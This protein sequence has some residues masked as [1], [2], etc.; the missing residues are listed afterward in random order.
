MKI[1]PKRGDF[2]AIRRRVRSGKNYVCVDALESSLWQWW[3]FKKE[4]SGEKREEGSI[5]RLLESEGRFWLILNSGWA[6]ILKAREKPTRQSISN[7]FFLILRKIEGK[8]LVQ[9]LYFLFLNE[10]NFYHL[11]RWIAVII[12]IVSKKYVRV[13]WRK[14]VIEKRPN[15][16]DIIWIVVCC[17]NIRI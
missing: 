3:L 8:S 5:D 14:S 2:R 15:P 17:I 7:G 1:F 9:F 12:W 11:K 13:Y 10:R 6:L 4:A 16:F